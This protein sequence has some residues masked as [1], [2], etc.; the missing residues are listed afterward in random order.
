MF[1]TGDVCYILE[2]NMRPRQAKISAKQGEFYVIQLIGSCGAIRLRE[3]RLFK[4][5]DEA[6]E[7]IKQQSKIQ[8]VDDLNDYGYIDVFKGKRKGSSPH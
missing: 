1:K 8:P 6:L 7:S 3:S 5:E 4:T 2:N